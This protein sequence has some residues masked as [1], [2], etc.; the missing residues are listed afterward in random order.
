MT[1]YDNTHV[2]TDELST[3]V[4]ELSVAG[5]PQY[6][7]AKIIKI[8]D[9]TLTKHYQYELTCSEPQVVARIARIVAMQAEDGC[10]KSQALLLKTRGSKYG[11]VEKHVVENVDSSETEA[12]KLKV[13]ELEGK[14]ASDY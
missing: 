8:D 6:L 7:I 1:L 9:E 10:T 14:F 5:I 3:Q 4:K 2:K 13:A 12:L 11:W